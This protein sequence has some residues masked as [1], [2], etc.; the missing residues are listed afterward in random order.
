VLHIHGFVHSNSHLCGKYLSADK[1]QN[2]AY[3]YNIY[4]FTY[5]YGQHNKTKQK[6]LLF[7]IKT[8]TCDVTKRE[9]IKYIGKTVYSHREM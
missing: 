8:Y 6:T 5:E 1:G 9:K 4:I 3:M 7:Y 2:F